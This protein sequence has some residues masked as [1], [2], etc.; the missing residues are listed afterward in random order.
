MTTH[1]SGHKHCGYHCVVTFAPDLPAYFERI[2]YSG[3]T[4]PTL[5]TLH[6]ILNRHITSI[7][8][9]NLDVLLGR[10]ISLD[11]EPIERKLIASRRGG[12]CF[13]QNG[14][15]LEILLALGYRATPLS[16]RVRIQT[17][18]DVVTPRT[19]LFVRVELDGAPWLCDVGVGGLSPTTALRLD[20]EAEQPTPH[21][22]RRIVRDGAAYFHQVKLGSTWE[23]V[24]EFTL[25]E[26]PRI[27]RDVANHWTSTHADSKFRKNLF[28]ARAGEKGTRYSIL[29]SEFTRRR[30][31]EILARAELKST[32]DLLFHL[33]TYFGLHLP[34][35]T[36][37]AIPEGPK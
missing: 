36:P 18:R 14:Y 11:P 12:Y 20:I 22:P 28:A 2:G 16:A 10:R 19:H 17:P 25:E 21:E 6:N 5:Q 4:A 8:F 23:D 35:D 13:E 30:G 3:P 37:L 7:P 15:L 34:P 32:E 27:D 33:S 29:N 24:Y 26:M 31:S 9:E 1:K